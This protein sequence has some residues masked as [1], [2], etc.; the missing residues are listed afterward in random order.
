MRPRGARPLLARH[1]RQRDTEPVTLTPVT[2]QKQLRAELARYLDPEAGHLTYLKSLSEEP[3][4]A[5]SAISPLRRFNGLVNL[6]NSHTKNLHTL[7]L[8]NIKVAVMQITC[9]I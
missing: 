8:I 5:S 4:G 3:A 6:L 1:R 7:V 2:V 9:S